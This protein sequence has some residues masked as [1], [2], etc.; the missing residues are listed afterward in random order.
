[1]D[2]EAHIA[3]LEAALADARMMPLS[4]S[5]LV[6]R[7]EFQAML[8]S[9]RQALPEEL[10]QSR[11]VIRERDEVVENARRDAERIL[12][13]ARQEAERLISETEVMQAAH[14]QAEE[15]VQEAREQARVMRLETEDYVE[16]KLARFEVILQKTLSQVEQGRE[17]LRGPLDHADG[18]EEPD[19]ESAGIGPQLYDHEELGGSA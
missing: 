19:D 17:R 11:W 3:Q 16:G 6:N 10:R 7:R 18:R 12:G 1:M 5:V 8:S 4:A 2:V 15:V 13:D 14:R 9:L